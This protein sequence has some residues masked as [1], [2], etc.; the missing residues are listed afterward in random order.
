MRHKVDHRKLG[1]PTDQRMH[2]LTNLQRQFIRHGYV[3]TT[4]GRAKELQRLVE[5][6]IT[7]TKH[8]DA[9]EARRPRPQGARRSLVVVHRAAEARRGQDR[10][11]E[12]AHQGRALAFERRGPRRPSLRQRRPP[13]PQPYVGLHPPRQDR[14]PPGRRRADRRSR[15]RRLTVGLTLRIK[16]V[17]AYDGTDFSG[18]ASQPNLRTVRGTLTEAVRLVSDE[19]VEITGSSRTDSGAHA[20]EQIVH[21]D[22]TRSVSAQEMGGDP[23]SA[24]PP[25]PVRPGLRRGAGAV[26][27]ALLRAGS[28]VSLSPPRRSARPASRPLR[29][30]AR[31][32][33]STRTPCGRPPSSS[34]ARTTFARSPRRSGATCSIRA[35]RF[36][37]SGCDRTRDEVWVDVVGTA[38]LRGMMRRISGCLLEIGRGHRS[39][40]EVS[41]LLDLQE[42]EQ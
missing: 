13:L 20:K 25:R 28:L 35:G 23:Q 39:V 10:A 4:F 8:E 18:W 38:F 34:S 19:S 42:R 32:R 24:A 37:M 14:S 31:R 17:V 9:L 3:R 16:L 2:L 5:K 22:T 33:R 30:P 40:S 26:P 15:T 11:R 41:R 27:R 6:L 7:L 12:D 29:A 36:S 21:F 1:L